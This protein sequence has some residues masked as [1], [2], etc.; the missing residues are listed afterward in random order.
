MAKTNVEE[1]RLA[2]RLLV[3]EVPIEI[4]ARRLTILTAVIRG[5]PQ[6][7]HH[8]KMYLNIILHL[9]GLPVGVSL[10]KFCGERR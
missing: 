9:L 3:Q 1:E 10:P 2:L 6:T 4:Q 7:S 8:Q 5:F